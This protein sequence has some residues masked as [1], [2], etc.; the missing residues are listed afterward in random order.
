MTEVLI[1]EISQGVV[2]ILAD[3]TNW[4]KRGFLSERIKATRYCMALMEMATMPSTHFCL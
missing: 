4:V 1:I 3:T 2:T